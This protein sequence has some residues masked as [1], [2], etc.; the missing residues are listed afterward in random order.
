MGKYSPLLPYEVYIIFNPSIRRLFAKVIELIINK[1]LATPAIIKAKNQSVLGLVV[2]LLREIKVSGKLYTIY[3]V[4][5]VKSAVY[6]L[7]F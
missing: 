3:P 1:R 7:K 6:P 2:K 4:K 5:D